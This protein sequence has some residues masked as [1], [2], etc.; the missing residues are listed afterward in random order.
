MKRRTVDRL[1]EKSR[2]VQALDFLWFRHMKVRLISLFSACV[3]SVSSFYTTGCVALAVGGAAVG[4]TAYVLGDLKVQVDASPKA[5]RSAIVAAGKDLGL[6]SVS[7]AGDELTGKYVFRNA[8]DQKIVISYE[9]QT[10]KVCDISI[11]VGNFGDEALSR[12][13][14]QAI[15]KRL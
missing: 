9:A 11:R 12:R 6:N 3:I 14:D 5:V 13:I 2:I 1:W 8:K 4:G 7:G 15:Q 10:P